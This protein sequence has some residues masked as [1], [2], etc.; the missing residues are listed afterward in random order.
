VSKIDE[1]RAQA[2]HLAAEVETKMAD[3]NLTNA[4]KSV[5]LDHAA[6]KNDEI[7]AGIK[8]LQQARQFMAANDDINDRPGFSTKSV[9]AAAAPGPLNAPEET[10]AELYDAAVHRKQFRA[11]ITTKAAFGVGSMSP[12]LAPLMVQSMTMG[13]PYEPDRLF[14]HFAPITTDAPAIEYLV[15][16]SNANPAAAVAEGAAKPDIGLVF[17]AKVLFPTKIAALANVTMEALQD[18]DSFAQVVPNELHRALVD[19]ETAQIAVGSGVGANMLGILNSTG[20]LTRSFPATGETALDC[21]ALAINDLRVGP[22][23]ARADLV[24][25]HPGTFSYLR[26]QKSTQGQYLLE[27]DPTEQ[28]ANSI[29]GIPVVQNTQIPGGKIIIMD[30]S[31]A[32]KAWVRMGLTMDVNYYD[33]QSWTTNAVSFRAEERIAYALTRPTAV[34][35]VTGLPFDTSATV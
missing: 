26:R 13:L 23:Y 14:E 16:S 12:G 17:A 7:T 2:K 1:L 19:A 35:I 25:M 34:N 6:A 32:V 10:W 5:F 31:Q 27:T 18:F 22:A 9:R 3:P 11:G 29:W 20:T 30:S 33:T 24:A 21:V 15:H 8:N 4:Q 28:E